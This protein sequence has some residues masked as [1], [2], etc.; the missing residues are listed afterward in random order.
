MQNREWRFYI[1]DM[2]DFCD[3]A[4]SY[5]SGMDFDEGENDAMHRHVIADLIR[6]PEVRGR[7][8]NKTTQPYPPLP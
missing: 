2:I 6:N 7:A 1:Q 4:L 8:D 3:K 5:T